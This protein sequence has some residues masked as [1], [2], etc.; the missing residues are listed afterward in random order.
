MEIKILLN[1]NLMPQFYRN[2]ALSF[3]KN[4]IKT[5]DKRVFAKLYETEKVLKKKPFSFE[6]FFKGTKVGDMYLVEKK[7]ILTFC[8]NN[9]EILGTFLK[10]L[11]VLSAKGYEFFVS[12]HLS[13]RAKP[14][15]LSINKK[16]ISNTLSFKNFLLPEMAENW[17]RNTDGMSLEE[18]VRVYFANQGLHIEEMLTVKVKASSKEKLME[19]VYNGIGWFSSEGF[20]Y[21]KPVKKAIWQRNK[22]IET[23]NC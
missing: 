21:T 18:K 9:A 20:G 19:V 13:D 15:I 16:L 17:K 10:G 23:N 7:P 2:Y 14:K 5:G 22:V 11:T 8:T 6:I 1:Q 4:A 3:V 12:E